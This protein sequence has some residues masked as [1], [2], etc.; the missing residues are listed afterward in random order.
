MINLHLADD[1]PGSG[2]PRQAPFPA[3]ARR[4]RAEVP[5]D[6]TNGRVVV[7]V[8]GKVVGVVGGVV[9]DGELDDA[10]PS[11]EPDEPV[12]N[13]AVVGGGAA[14]V[15]VVAVMSGAPEL[16]PDVG[17]DAPGCSRATST[18]TN[19]APAPDSTTNV[20]VSR[21]RRRCAR[22]RVAA[23]KGPEARFMFEDPGAQ[24]RAVSMGS[25]AQ[26]GS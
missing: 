18:P 24:A 7:V 21:R 9:T 1:R 23:E 2:S 3:L 15:V 16:D 11:A 5:P 12:T 4:Q 14:I 17:A 6:V 19:A 26:A 20:V 22:S 13:G 8:G 10:P 25:S